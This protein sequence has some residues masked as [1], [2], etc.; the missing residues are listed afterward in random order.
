[1]NNPTN[2]SDHPSMYRIS[3]DTGGTFTDVVVVDAENNVYMS[4]ALTSLDRAYSAIEEGLGRIAKTMG[5]SVESIV[6]E[7]IEINYGTTRSTNLVVTGKTART[8]LFTTRGFPDVLLLKE[9]GK[10]GPF[11]RLRYRDPLIPRYLTFEID[12]RVTSNGTVSS[13]LDEKS[14]IEAINSARDS[15]VEAVAVSF[16]WSVANP[17]HELQVGELLAQ[18]MPGVP[19]T[20]SH[21][22]NPSIREY[23]RASAAAIDASLKPAMQDFFFGLDEDLHSV[24]FT[25]S[26]LI[27]TSYGGGWDAQRIAGMPVYSIGSGPSMA[28][29][30]ALQ[31]AEIDSATSTDRSTILVT[32]MG[33]TTFDLSVI[34]NGRVERTSETWLGG[35]WVGDITGTRSVDVESIGAGGGSI[36]WIDPG[37][38]LQVG[39]QSAGS[40]PGPACYGQGG[41]NP[42][43]TDAAIILGYLD[44]SNFVGGTLELHEDLARK[45]LAPVAEK[46]GMSLEAAADA[47]MHISVDNIITAIRA[48]T[49]SKGI[50]LRGIT[51]VAGGGASGIT[52]G[53]IA[54]ELNVGEVILP[55]AAGAMSAYGA[56]HA[57][58]ISEYEVVT[59]DTTARPDFRLSMD[60]LSELEQRCTEFFTSLDTLSVDGS[61]TSVE[62][63]VQARY[64]MQAWEMTIPLGSLQFASS[65]DATAIEELF[66]SEHLR[67]FGVREHT[68]RVEILAIGARA[69]VSTGR[70]AHS[71][72]FIDT[73]TNSRSLETRPTFFGSAGWIETNIFSSADVVSQGWVD[74]PAIVR[75]ETTT[76]IVNPGQRLEARPSSNYLLHTDTKETQDHDKNDQIGA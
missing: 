51:L 65:L 35:Q 57:D 21:Q 46:L 76:I 10:P 9:G 73:E 20:L 1:M 26:L 30:A 8:A 69:A 75:E 23:R 71:A 29:V 12:E 27:S 3:V 34:Q 13:V 33:G 41:M 67:I 18:H 59:H 39:P 37:G 54:K 4:K 28:P 24:G 43:I 17:S 60:R 55:K 49:V 58:V 66:H 63:S 45:A 47:A 7:A 14:V 53:R 62:Y 11:H 38:L 25:G 42:T 5:T 48:K 15:G 44:S 2:E 68:S 31:E 64:P 61:T 72:T 6:R 70:A 74:G 36:V 16:L 22:V 40:A 56:L 50:D 19:V 32:D 52:V